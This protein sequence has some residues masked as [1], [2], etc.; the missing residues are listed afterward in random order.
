MTTNFPR[1]FNF[2]L[3]IAAWQAYRVAG[4]VFRIVFG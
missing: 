3:I 1:Y 2:I 4:A